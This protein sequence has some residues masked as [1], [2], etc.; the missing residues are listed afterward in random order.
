VIQIALLEVPGEVQDVAPETED[1][2][3]FYEIEVLP[4]EGVETELE[5]AA[6]T[7]EVLK[8]GAEKQGCDKDDDA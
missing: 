2:M 6:E 3:Q 7:G 4:S 1:G 8:V 5:I